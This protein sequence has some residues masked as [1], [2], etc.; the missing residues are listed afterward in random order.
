MV[1][2]VE[3]LNRTGREHGVGRLDVV[4]DRLVGIK[5]RAIYEAPAATVLVAAHRDLEQLTLTRDALAGK[6]PLEQRVSEMAYEGLWFSPLN[7]AIEA[8][9]KSLEM[10]VTGTVRV[11]L[12]SLIHISEPTRLG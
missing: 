7:R 1:G 4:E 5:S 12:L 9:N 2:L 3:S 6:R 11:K 8:F 10:R